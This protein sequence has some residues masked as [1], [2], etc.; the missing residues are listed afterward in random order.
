MLALLTVRNLAIVE[1]ASVPFEPG[2][3]VITGE[4]GAGKSVLMGALGLILGERTDKALIRHGEKEGSVCAVFQLAD[5]VGIDAILEEAG[6]PPCEGGELVIRRAVSIAGAG[7]AAVNDTPAT[8]A[9]LRRLARHLIDIH[10]P[11]DQQTLLDPAFQRDLLTAYA[12]AS[13]PFAAYRAAWLSLQ[14][15][16]TALDALQGDPAEREQEIDRLAFAVKEI[17]DAAPTAADDDDLI[18]RHAQAANAEAILQAGSAVTDALTDGETSLFDQLVRLRGDLAET[19]R[20]LPD[21]AAW[22]DEL[23]A[24]AVQ[25]QELGRAIASRLQSI[26]ADPAALEALETRMAQIQRL[27]RRYGKT[28]EEILERRRRDKTRLD[29]LASH[30]DRLEALTR[31]VAQAETDLLRAGKTLSEARRRAIPALEKA[32]SAELRDLGFARAGFA[33]LC[34]ETAPGPSGLDEVTFC[35]APNPGEAAR[36]LRAIASSGETARVMLAVKAV[37]ARHDR[38][39]TLIFDEIDANIGGETGRAVGIKLR[40]VA[41]GRQIICITHQPQAAVY[42]QHH[43]KVTKE[44]RSGRTVTAIEPLEGDARADEIARMLGGRDLTSVTLDHA[45]EML[46]AGRLEGQQP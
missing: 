35:F 15:A 22:V 10:G 9:L 2:L 21:A 19:A 8:A 28:V 38:I 32:I 16:Q 1:E 42:G 24:I 12:A 43:F 40:R 36:P 33:I 11:Y 39:P 45:R 18:A 31:A 20:L 41:E 44:T 29:D 37:L 7:K 17:D 34:E 30:D 5:T 25:I 14:E 6:L 13:A 27:K 4:T 3:N 46:R 23:R 26:D